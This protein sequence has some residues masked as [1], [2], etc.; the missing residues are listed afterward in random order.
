MKRF[1]V[2]VIDIYI[3]EAD[4]EDEAL[5]IALDVAEG[6]SDCGDWIGGDSSVREI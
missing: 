5:D 1:E 3:V 2:K 4:T 6:E